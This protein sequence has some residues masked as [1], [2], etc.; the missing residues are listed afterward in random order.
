MEP[1]EVGETRNEKPKRNGSERTDPQ[2][3]KRLEGFELCFPQTS[4]RLPG[5]EISLVFP[6]THEGFREPRFQVCSFIKLTRRWYLVLGLDDVLARCLG[7]C[8]EA[9]RPWVVAVG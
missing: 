7:T 5:V 3:Q 2:H 6:D 9:M 8:F 1:T 4:K